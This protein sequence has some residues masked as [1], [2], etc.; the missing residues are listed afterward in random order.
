MFV[1]LFDPLAYVSKLLQKELQKN[2]RNTL[3]GSRKLSTVWKFKKNRYAQCF[4]R[5]ERKNCQHFTIKPYIL[6]KFHTFCKLILTRHNNIISIHTGCQD[7]PAFSVSMI[8]LFDTKI[9]L[10]LAEKQ[11]QEKTIEPLKRTLLIKKNP[12]MLFFI[13]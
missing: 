9:L 10:A 7:W 4:L 13:F 11:K 3:K 1:C 2:A 12:L 5:N 6:C 8:H